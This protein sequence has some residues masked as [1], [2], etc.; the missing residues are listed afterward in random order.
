MARFSLLSTDGRKD[1]AGCQ[2]SLLAW[3]VQGILMH[4]LGMILTCN[5][6]FVFLFA[7]WEFCLCLL[8]GPQ[9]AVSNVQ[10]NDTLVD[11]DNKIPAQDM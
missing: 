6:F 5:S 7:K 8:L 2:Y 4:S 9:S 11:L 10:G 1:L 3:L